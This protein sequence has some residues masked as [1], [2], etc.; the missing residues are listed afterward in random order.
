MK[1]MLLNSK[2]QFV[3]CNVTVWED[4]VKVFELAKA[5]SPHKSCDIVIANAGISGPDPL[6]TLDGENISI[7]TCSRAN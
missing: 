6:F 7:S 5:N 1:L 3:E 4:Q 2:A